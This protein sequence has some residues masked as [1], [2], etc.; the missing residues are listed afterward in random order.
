MRGLGFLQA[1]SVEWNALTT[2][3]DANAEHGRKVYRFLRD[4]LGAQFIQF[5]PIIE[6]VAETD[7][8]GA[9][10]WTSWRDRPLYTQRGNRITGRSVSAEST[11]AS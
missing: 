10:P 11:A 4:D 5:I 7:E 2:I 8:D 9:V 1:A 3:H 6:R